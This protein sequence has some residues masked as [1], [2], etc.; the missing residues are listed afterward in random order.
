MA[1]RA[2]AQGRRL[3]DFGTGIRVLLESAVSTA[4]PEGDPRIYGHHLFVY[5]RDRFVTCWLLPPEIR[6]LLS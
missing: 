4:H 1:E 6:R 5:E 3:S 2:L